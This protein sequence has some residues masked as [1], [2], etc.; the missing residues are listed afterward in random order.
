IS[1]LLDMSALDSGRMQI[2][3]ESIDIV[4][5]VAEAV[6]DA[7]PTAQA[8]DHRLSARLPD[9]LLAFADRRRVLQV[10]A[11]LVN[12][13]V[14]YTPPGGNIEVSVE[15]REGSVEVRVRDNGIGIPVTEQ[16]Q[17]FEKF[18]RTSTGRRTTGGTGLGLAIA[19]SL[20]ELH[21]GSIWVES[22]GE[23]GSTFAFTLPTRPI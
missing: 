13:A 20:I 4:T 19:R 12:N 5:V 21:G 14:K 23:S 22:D 7:Q 1:D 16:T 15:Q 10:L 18:F 3:P 8:K 11:N 9:D 6:T 2:Q 17:L